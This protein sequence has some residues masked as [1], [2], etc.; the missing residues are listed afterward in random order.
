[1]INSL[2]RLL[3]KLVSVSI[4]SLF[5]DSRPRECALAGIEASGLWLEGPEL[6]KKRL[7]GDS[8]N[9]ESP[10]FVPFAQIFYLIEAESMQQFSEKETEPSEPEG[11]PSKG[12]PR[13][14]KHRGR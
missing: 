1:M 2:G 7:H 11:I 3:N 5:D 13:K 12:V 6:A 4:P 9:P 10:I 14:K 8:D